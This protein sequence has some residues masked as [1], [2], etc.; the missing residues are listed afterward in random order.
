VLVFD[1]ARTSING[2]DLYLINADGT[3][4]RPIVTHPGEGEPDDTHADF[5]PAW[6]P[7][8]DTI[9][10]TSDR[11]GNQDIWTTNEIGHSTGRLVTSPAADHSPAWAPDGESIAFASNRNGNDDIYAMS[12]DGLELRQLTTNA[13]PDTAPAWSP[14]G[15]RIAFASR[16]G[17]NWDIYVIGADGSD[18]RRLTTD[19]ARDINPSWSADGESIIFTSDRDGGSGLYVMDAMGGAVRRIT[20]A[21]ENAD[22]AA[23]RPQVD[24]QLGLRAPRTIARGALARIRIVI[25]NQSPT[26]AVRVALGVD[27]PATARL[28]AIRAPGGQCATARS[29]RCSFR[30]L[31]PDA[32]V[33]VNATLRL[34]RC[35]R[36]TISA[37][38]SSLQLDADARDNR[39]RQA[40]RVAC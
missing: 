3:Q 6:S 26:I 4:E 35:G 31:S 8:T 32:S 1:S 25:R 29:P 23:W 11:T 21:S 22:G 30:R 15:R 12:F 20:P 16:R 2:L 39:E 9:I 17:E 33:A 38:A 19:S 28:V 18:E 36:A 7:V 10:F 13:A 5:D 40:L 27:L 34:T 24:L 14:D 37:S